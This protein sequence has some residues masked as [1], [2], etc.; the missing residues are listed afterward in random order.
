MSSSTVPYPFYRV[1]L[2]LQAFLHI[3]QT[4]IRINNNS[5]PLPTPFTF[6]LILRRRSTPPATAK[7]NKSKSMIV[8][9]IKICYDKKLRVTFTSKLHSEGKGIV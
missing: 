9:L 1:F 6:I 2:N 8:S 7:S 3:F 4:F 5:I